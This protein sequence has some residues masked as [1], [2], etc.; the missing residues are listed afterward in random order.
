MVRWPPWTNRCT[1]ASVTAKSSPCL[2][3]FRAQERRGSNLHS[4]RNA[5]SAAH[6]ESHARQADPHPEPPETEAARRTPIP[7]RA[8]PAGVAQRPVGSPPVPPTPMPSRRIGSLPSK[9][10]LSLLTSGVCR[11]PREKLGMMSANVTPARS[12]STSR[13]HA[14]RR[15]PGRPRHEER[16][17]V[18]PLATVVPG[19]RCTDG[20]PGRVRFAIVAPTLHPASTSCGGARLPS[21]EHRRMWGS[22]GSH[23][24]PGQLWTACGIGRRCPGPRPEKRMDTCRRRDPFSFLAPFPARTSTWTRKGERLGSGRARRSACP[25]W[26]ARPTSGSA[27]SSLHLPSSKDD[28]TIV[29]LEHHKQGGLL[30]MSPRM[31]VWCDRP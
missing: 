6:P 25:A 28:T 16:A 3:H 27:S 31:P 18:V 7:R 5:R 4:L 15:S 24:G 26:R 8:R 23:A 22:P 11:A 29:G 13:R 14:P 9:A 12:R 17:S 10:R 20:I 30:L 1:H 2:S 21:R 19:E